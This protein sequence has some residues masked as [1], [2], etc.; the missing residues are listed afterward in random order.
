[1]GL[2]VRTYMKKRDL[3]LLGNWLIEPTQTL[4][5]NRSEKTKKLQ[6]AL[7]CKDP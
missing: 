6:F 2:S 4:C 7:R 3:G 5:R 1:M